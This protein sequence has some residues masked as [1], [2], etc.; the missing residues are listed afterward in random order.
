MMRISRGTFVAG[1]ATVGLVP[2]AT[3]AAVFEFKCASTLAY[4]HPA[5]I[6]AKQ[7]WQV[8]ER[9]SGGR[10]RVQFYPNGMLGSNESLL[11]QLRLNAIQFY[12]NLG[13][14]PGLIPAVDITNVA[15]AFQDADHAFHAVDGPLGEYLR[16]EFAAKGLYLPRSFWDSG[17]P[18]HD[19]RSAYPSTRG[20]VRPQDADREQPDRRRFL[21]HA[22]RKPGFH[23]H[24]GAL[25]GATNARRR[26]RG[27]PTGNDRGIPLV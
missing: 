5:S 25:H 11:S 27:R 3:R 2:L 10:L 23:G 26:R 6:R 1:A 7:M 21:P 15:F 13:D 16:K 18:D 14:L 19:Q 9:E 22:W 4:D 20:R 12:M 24:T 8:I 17:M